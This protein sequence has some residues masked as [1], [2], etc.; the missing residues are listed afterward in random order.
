MVQ[1]LLSAWFPA[2]CAAYPSLPSALTSPWKLHPDGLSGLRQTAAT[3]ITVR[4]RGLQMPS[5]LEACAEQRAQLWSERSAV[6]SVQEAVVFGAVCFAAGTSGLDVTRAVCAHHS[7][8][9]CAEQLPLENVQWE[10]P[11]EGES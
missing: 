9:L 6:G 1:V 8:Y 5:L 3:W 11:A 7:C 10:L 2:P 4:A